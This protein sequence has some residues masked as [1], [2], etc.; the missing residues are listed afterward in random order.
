MKDWQ[1]LPYQPAPCASLCRGLFVVCGLDGLLDGQ[2]KA[3][4]PGWPRL[5]L[6]AC[7]GALLGILEGLRLLTATGAPDVLSLTGGSDSANP[8]S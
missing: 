3:C 1:F 5:Y 7:G 4:N 8:I 2:E 6:S